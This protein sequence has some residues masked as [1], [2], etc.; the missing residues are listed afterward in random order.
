M[1][2]RSR[3]PFCLILLALLLV[4]ASSAPASP[5]PLFLGKWGTFCDTGTSGVDG[6]DGQFNYPYG[7]TVGASGN[8][9]VADTGNDRI[10]KFDSTG[11]FLGKWGTY[12]TGDGQFHDPESVA[13]HLSGDV[14]VTDTFNYRIQKFDSNGTLLLMWGW[15]VDDGSGEF[16]TCTSDCQK[17]IIG[18]GDGQLDDPYGV[19]VDASGNVY[20]AEEGNH[21]VQKFDSTGSFVTKWGT[22]GSGDDELNSPA[23]VAVDSS[24]Q[25]YVADAANNRIQKFD[26]NGT[27]L[28]MWGWGVDD[29][30]SEFQT[31]TSGCQSGI[32][33][34]GDGQFDDPIGVWVDAS[35]I[36]Y[37]AGQYNHRIQKFDSTGT[38]LGK[39]GTYGSGD[40]QLD[41]PF[42]V[43]VDASGN[44]Y[45]DD[46]YN[47]R[48]QKFG[49]ALDFFVGEPEP[50]SGQ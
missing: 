46:Q 4:A 8:V 42:D 25:V 19:A 41:N 31:C 22:Y 44:V 45:V 9:Y 15:G 17:G 30:S 6:C 10:Q 48:I 18:S 32:S 28:L 16:Q 35:G 34:A 33:G 40:G 37:V 3:Y 43:A 13:V 24:G 38:F 47:N 14:Y 21:R 39:W 27:S 26:S 29:G 23:G 11:T 50:P 5:P 2:S 1:T 36:V 12:G 7:M 20:V 49:P